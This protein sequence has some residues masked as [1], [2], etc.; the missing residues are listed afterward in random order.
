ME[1]LSALGH[2][3]FM[4][5]VVHYPCG[6]VPITEVKESEEAYYI[7]TH[8]DMWTKSIRSSL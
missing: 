2:Y 5:N 1:E 7:D 6:V 8:N 3:F 4:W